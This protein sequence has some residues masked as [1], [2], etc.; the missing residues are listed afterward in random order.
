ME[1]PGDLCPSCN[2]LP[3]GDFIGG[4]SRTSCD[5]GVLTLEAAQ[6]E[7]LINSRLQACKRKASQVALLDGFKP[8]I[9]QPVSFSFAI[10]P[11]AF[12][13]E[14]A[15][16][17]DVLKLLHAH[18]RDFRIRFQASDHTYYID[19]VQT[20]GS[21]TG[22]IHAFSQ[23]FDA[24]VV[25]SKMMNG[26]NWP[27][28]GYLKHE[29][30]LTW[31]SRLCVHCPDLLHL[32]AGNPRDDARISKALRDI[33]CYHD[34]SDEL[35][36]LTLSR[37]A[38][39]AMWNAAGREAARYGTYMHYLFEALLNGYSVPTVSP[40]VRMLQSFLRGVTGNSTAWRTEWTIF[41]DAERLAG[42]IDFCM[43]LPDGSLML[44]DWKR[45][46]GLHGK[47]QAYQA[48][49]P[50]I[51]HIA[52]CAG[53]H[54]RLQLN[55]YRHILE[56]CYNFRVSRMLV[57]CCHPE[58][59]PQAFV[60]DV[61]RLEREVEDLLQAWIDV[62]GGSQAQ[63]P[64]PLAKAIR[65]YLFFDRVRL[66]KHFAL[67]NIHE[68]TAFPRLWTL[69]PAPF[70]SPHNDRDWRFWLSSAIQHC[71]AASQAMPRDI[72][73]RQRSGCTTTDMDRC[74]KRLFA[75]VVLLLEL[76]PH[77]D[78]VDFSLWP[79]PFDTS[80]SKRC[81]ERWCL[82]MRSAIRVVNGDGGVVTNSNRPSHV[83][84]ETVSSNRR[85]DVE[86]GSISPG[87]VCSMPE[88]I[89][90]ALPGHFFSYRYLGALAAVSRT[91][92]AGVRDRRLWRNKNIFIDN[93]EFQDVALL[94]RMADLWDGS[95]SINV[96]LVQL[97]MFLRFPDNLRLMWDAEA[98]PPAET[99][100][101]SFYGI[102][103]R[104][105]LMGY[106]HFDLVV[107]S[108]VTGLYIG[109][110]D[111]SSTR[112]SYVRV[113][114]VFGAGM[115]WSISLGGSA[116]VPHQLSNPH[117][118]LAEQANRVLLSWQQDRF[119]LIM[120]GHRL[121]ARS[122]GP[123][124]AAAPPLSRLFIWSF[125]RGH[126]TGEM[127]HKLMNVTPQPSPV[128][129]NAQ[130]R[131]AV[132]H[133][134][135]SLLFPQWCICP[136]CSTWSCARHVGELPWRQCPRCPALLADYVGGS[137]KAEQTM[138]GGVS[139]LCC[140]TYSDSDKASRVRA[141]LGN[142]VVDVCG[143]ASQEESLMPEF[144]NRPDEDDEM[145]IAEFPAP[146]QD[147]AASAKD[148]EPNLTQDLEELVEEVLFMQESESKRSDDVL[149]VARKRRLLP[150]AD[151]TASDFAATFAALRDRADNSF[152]NVQRMHLA[153]ELSIPEQVRRLRNQILQQFPGLNEQVLRVTIGALSVYRLRLTDMHVREMVLLLWVVEGESHMRCHNGNLYFFH[154]G[155]FAIHRGI[156]PQGTLARCKRFFLHLEG[157]FRLM[158]NAQLMTDDNV[159]SQ[160]ERLLSDNN[161]SAQQFLNSCED[162]ARGHVPARGG[163]R[164][165]RSVFADAVNPGEPDDGFAG[166]AGG[167]CEGIADSLT[168]AGFTLQNKLLEDKIFSLVV[169]W[170]D[171]PQTRTAGV[172]YKDCAVVYSTSPDEQPVRW[173]LG[174]PED[175]LYIH[176]P[177]PLLDPVQECAQSRL[178]R[179]YAE[180]FWL[181]NDVARLG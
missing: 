147:D 80:I 20:K 50:P 162:A 179:F 81:W 101:Q 12:D 111:W 116:P 92:L 34:I 115:I 14:T 173:A 150:G 127:Q 41:G 61:P 113:D 5:N 22:M 170:C 103:S 85:V 59:Y 9:R 180:T 28:A 84:S 60:D 65:E 64:N 44:V 13:P 23:P 138:F 129:L 2:L 49:R 52:D 152:A 21:V 108:T 35:A 105:P 106:A 75:Q 99:G 100:T 171:S 130:I 4:S 1:T 56:K 137:V 172:A 124:P 110:K 67:Q 123:G 43:R 26:R 27:R 76:I 165:G 144:G 164:R 104:Q 17:V 143:G 117:V 55:V 48:M 153:H 139:P 157:F 19:G 168:K 93:I 7:R 112:R 32:Y 97:S 8:R 167:R 82:D 54:Y 135:K 88:E 72:V 132:C 145:D 122:S 119:E 16:N 163:V 169:E 95:R 51:S 120:N 25:I 140:P 66:L 134:D 77:A 29:V 177:H 160:M 166:H 31:M 91:L 158:G 62:S 151:T 87:R 178:E 121:N 37:D 175:N 18:P 11:L 136:R 131:C 86:G 10:S 89:L 71:H 69:F 142:A 57:V 98:S 133:A 30:S 3:L 68:I 148:H 63:L 38:I 58:H 114:N 15:P 36:Q 141:P 42:S 96:N 33:A 149:G 70:S 47:Y 79:S 181:N 74:S 45:T 94:R 118:L 176:I 155:A 40:E 161:D 78:V 107:P 53:M 83:S 73:L 109:V 126:Q 102:V 24:D 125:T 39:K 174:R 128:M 90:K 46:S 6:R 146:E 154:S 159:L 156:P